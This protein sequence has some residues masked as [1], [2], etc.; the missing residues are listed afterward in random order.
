MKMFQNNYQ[1]L[2]Q[3]NIDE[4]V[5]LLEE[6]YDTLSRMMHY[7]MGHNISL[8]ELEVIKKDLIGIAKEAEVEGIS[9]ESKLGVSEREFCNSLLVDAVRKKPLDNVFLQCKDVF[10]AVCLINALEFFCSGFPREYGLCLSALLYGVGVVLTKEIAFDKIR[11]RATYSKNRNL[12][13]LVSG[14]C[15][16]AL[17]FAWIVSPGEDIFLISGNGWTITAILIFVTVFAF[18][19]NN[20]YW[21]KQ[22]ERYSWE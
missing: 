16:A 12:I 18:L 3:E 1:R 2:R 20:L 21:N 15:S 19:V 22:S 9:L 11:K 10:L 4:S 5:S 8:F 6:N 13:N 7:M 17:V 14:L